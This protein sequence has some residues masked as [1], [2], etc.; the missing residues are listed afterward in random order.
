MI[1]YCEGRRIKVKEITI[2]ELIKLIKEDKAPSKV[3]Y[4]DRVWN[5]N[6]KAQDYY[7]RK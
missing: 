2:Y 7:I 5:Q 6:E 1:C 3:I 4:D